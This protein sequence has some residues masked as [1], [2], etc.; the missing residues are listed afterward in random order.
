[1][2]LQTQILWSKAEGQIDYNSQLLLL[3][4]CFVENIGKK[5]SYY[6]FRS[7]SNPLG[8]LFHPLAIEKVVARAI[9]EK[10]YTLQETFFLNERWH[11]YDAHSSLSDV[12]QE[13]LVKNLNRGLR[14]IRERII[15]GT[16]FCITLGTAWAYRNKET[17]RLVAN[18]HKVPQQ[19]FTKELISVDGI[20]KSITR[21]L[22]NIMSVNAKAKCIFTVSPVRHLK[23]G[24]IE[25]QRSKGHLI[26]GLHKALA[27]ARTSGAGNSAYFPSYEIMMDELRDYRFYTADMIHPNTVAI[28]YIWEKF[29]QIWISETAFPVMKEVES[30][31]KGL[32]HRPF[33]PGTTQHQQF[34]KSIQMKIKKLQKA[35]TFMEFSE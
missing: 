8:I 31:Q 12:S 22:N 9:A 3:G 6:K 21:I 24:F 4:S 29:K 14:S 7:S 28:D 33:Y 17:D 15:N 19:C 11:C 1:M 13:V 34:L 25:N 30:I 2:Q 5:I 20:S 27:D 26:A 32:Q 18:C 35:Y 16:H 10:E 23:D